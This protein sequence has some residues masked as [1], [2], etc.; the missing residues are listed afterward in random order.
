MWL[1]TE[2]GLSWLGLVG[3]RVRLC[4]SGLGWVALEYLGVGLVRLK[5]VQVG[6]FGLVLDLVEL[7]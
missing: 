7:K 2:G 5:L 4:S 6:W 3:K 1:G